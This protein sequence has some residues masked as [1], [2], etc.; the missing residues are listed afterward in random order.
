LPLF[1]EHLPK[2]FLATFANHA[3]LASLLPLFDFAVD[4]LPAHCCT[5]LAEAPFLELSFVLAFAVARLAALIK[6]RNTG[7]IPYLFVNPSTSL[8]WA[9]MLLSV[10]SLST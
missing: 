9:M 10:S 3:H 7:W 6:L 1:D 8:M 5:I 4:S 2:K